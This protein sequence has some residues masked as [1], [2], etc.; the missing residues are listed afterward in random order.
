VGPKAK[1]DGQLTDTPGRFRDHPITTDPAYVPLVYHRDPRGQAVVIQRI[2]LGEA[3]PV[4]EILI[5]P[6]DT[7]QTQPLITDGTFPDWLP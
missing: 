6:A 7:G 4:P 2:K 3:H 1:R 5:L